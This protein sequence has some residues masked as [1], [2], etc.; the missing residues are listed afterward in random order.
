MPSTSKTT[1]RFV[2]AAVA[3]TTLVVLVGA[4][5]LGAVQSPATPSAPSAT[6]NGSTTPT[7]PIATATPSPTAAPLDDVAVVLDTIDAPHPRVTID[8]RTGG[9]T[10]A[11][12]GHAGDGMSTRWNTAIVD[13][14]DARTIRV[15]WVG[16]PGDEDVELRLVVRT[17]TLVLDVDQNGPP[18]N[19][20]ALGADRVLEL[21]FDHDVNAD[22]VTVVFPPLVSAG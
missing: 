3:A 5:A 18:A 12:S 11:R 20:D 2:A 16:F 10:D 19:S 17:G 8:D 4:V 7:E 14:V 6:P 15:T 22:D 21:A 1:G 13:Q 9:L